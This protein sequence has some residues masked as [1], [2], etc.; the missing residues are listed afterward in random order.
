ML[1]QLN[2]TNFKCFELLKLPL[3]ALTLLSGANAS[4]KSSILQALVLLHQTFR[5]NPRSPRL[6]LNGS[7]VNLG[8]VTDVMDQVH[9]SDRL[10]IG[11]IDETVSCEW[12]FSGGR[13]DMSLAIA[14]VTVGGQTYYDPAPKGILGFHLLPDIWWTTRAKTARRRNADLAAAPRLDAIL[15]EER[16]ALEEERA[17]R[18]V[19]EFIAREEE[20]VARGVEFAVAAWRRERVTAA[21]LEEERAAV[22]LQEEENAALREENAARRLAQR[23][24][25][26]TYITAEREG[27][28]DIYTLA[29][30]TV[31]AVGPT[32]ENAASVLYQ[33]L[34]ERI[35]EAEE[36]I[37]PGVVPTLLPQVEARLGAFFP[38]CAL[39]V[40]QVP[41]VNAVTLGIRIS[42]D[43]DF[44]RPVH[45]GFGITQVL[46]IIVAALSVPKDSILLIENPE[47]HLHPS[48]QARMGQ[49]LAEVAHAGVQVIVETHSDHILNGIRRAVK[50]A[51]LP[52]EE[53]AIHFFR[54]RSA[55]S[56]Q[57]LTPT[58]DR[59]GNIDVWP[60]GFFDQFDKDL[61]YFAGWGE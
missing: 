42:P 28:R 44:L 37:L 49:F 22:A 3:G 17:A 55:G 47:V 30:E 53:V 54:P 52:A 12:S 32:G 31:I 11:L 41:N 57:V 4:G 24:Q 23:L 7:V 18:K 15:E 36:R 46:P 5:D 21:L 19:A 45:C 50:S 2:L 9:G 8:S 38:G 34:G 58:L 10:G 20:L 33:G 16:A 25:N 35:D 14:Q 51:Q 13:R 56:P 6:M 27:P 43:T 59:S 29:N 40:Q 1:T 39:Q 61:D 48:G 26:L 60:E